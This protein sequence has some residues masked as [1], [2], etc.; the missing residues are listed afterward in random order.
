MART[1]QNRAVRHGAAHRT[2]VA[3]RVP[4][5]APPARCRRIRR[6]PTAGDLVA[7]EAET[8]HRTQ[9]AKQKGQRV[10]CSPSVSADVRNR[11]TQAGFVLAPNLTRNVVT[12]IV[13]A[14]DQDN[15]KVARARELAAPIWPSTTCWD[16]RHHFLDIPAV[17]PHSRRGPRRD[18]I[19]DGAD[20]CCFGARSHSTNTAGHRWLVPGPVRTVDLPLLGRPTLDREGQRR[21]RPYVVGQHPPTAVVCAHHRRTGRRPPAAHSHGPHHDNAEERHPRSTAPDRPMH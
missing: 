19:P 20:T 8:T 21:R 12:A 3:H 16:H 13:A 18:R 2:A 10:W 17:R 7:P 6:A 14:A 4:P 11:L 5:R 15:T 9:A 1:D